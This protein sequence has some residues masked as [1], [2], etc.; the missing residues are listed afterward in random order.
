MASSPV[1][2]VIRT[3]RV[4]A[5]TMVTLYKLPEWYH[6]I[7]S[8][9][10]YHWKGCLAENESL[11]DADESDTG[12]ADREVPPQ[13]HSSK[14]VLHHSGHHHPKTMQ[15]TP[16][17][18]AVQQHSLT[19]SPPGQGASYRAQSEDDQE[20]F[21]YSPPPPNQ[22]ALHKHIK[23][24]VYVD[25]PTFKPSAYKGKGKAKAIPQDQE[26]EGTSGSETVDSNLQ[27][28]D[29]SNDKDKTYQLNSDNEGDEE[30][31]FELSQDD[32]GQEDEDIIHHDRGKDGSSE[33]EDEEDVERLLEDA[34]VVLADLIEEEALM[35]VNEDMAEAEHKAQHTQPK[36]CKKKVGCPSQDFE[37]QMR[38]TGH[39]VKNALAVIAKKFGVTLE[40]KLLGHSRKGH[41]KAADGNGNGGTDNDSDSDLDSDLD[42]DGDADSTADGEVDIDKLYHEIV[43][44]MTAEERRKFTMDCD[45][46]IAVIKLEKGIQKMK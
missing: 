4:V 21:N 25:V 38:Y 40:Q 23:K 29:A 39:Q 16:Q 24:Q 19:P 45:D 36:H 12:A 33:Q 42:E 14:I 32:A 3:T 30:E 18:Q 5:Y 26:E 1:A 17:E 15:L 43:D 41:K 22:L 8:H 44:G 35:D 46:R 20:E 34:E 13:W 2:L 37:E 10:P 11:D 31:V 28:S 6:G 9:S 27:E 7:S